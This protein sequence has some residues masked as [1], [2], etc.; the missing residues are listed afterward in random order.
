[1]MWTRLSGLFLLLFLSI[2]TFRS[3]AL[4][5]SVA[6][7][8]NAN[9]DT[10]SAIDADPTSQTFNMVIGNPIAVGD[11]P[12]GIAITPDGR[13]AYVTGGGISV[14]DTDPTSQ[15]FNM[16]IGNPIGVGTFPF[17]IA[18][19]PDGRHAY[20]TNQG[21]DTVSVIDTDFNM[22]CRL[23][24]TARAASSVARFASGLRS[25]GSSPPPPLRPLSTPPFRCPSY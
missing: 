11:V 22:V 1:M 17:G 16:V 25:P 21:D 12:F 5:Q 19:T 13:H 4:A 2:V 9:D 6:Y 8:A 18:I 15:T 23:T 3:A 20:V 7:V 10:V 24:P 14:I